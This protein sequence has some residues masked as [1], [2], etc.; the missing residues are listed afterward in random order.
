[1][2]IRTFIAVEID[3]E[4]RDRL[5]E[6]I[7]QLKNADADVKWI[8]P[9]NIHLTLKFVGNVKEDILP[10]LNK[11]IGDAASCASPFKM[12]IE[13]VGAFPT[14]K[15]P[16]VIFVCAQE[17][18]DNLLKIYESI[19]VNL[20]KLGIKKDSRK[21]VGHITLGRVKSQKNMK[22]LINAL[23]FDGVN[24]FGQEKVNSISLMRS[25]LTPSGPIYTRL[26]SFEVGIK[27]EY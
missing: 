25:V 13:K 10:D 14:I 22:K 26:N 23:N 8:S 4:I 18:G 1:M 6:F 15:R 5:Y 16:H 2:S 27:N 24:S 21:F 7:T 3:D 20:E 11:I 17:K 9:E 19:D 12:N